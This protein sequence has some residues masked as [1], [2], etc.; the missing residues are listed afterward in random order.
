MVVFQK[1]K[2]I[3]NYFYSFFKATNSL[4]F[5][6]SNHFLPEKMPLYCCGVEKISFNSISSLKMYI[7]YFRYCIAKCSGRCI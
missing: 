6:A 7:Y 1:S 2:F 4:A 5:N 3:Y